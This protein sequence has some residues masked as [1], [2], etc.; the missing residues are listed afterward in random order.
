MS[1]SSITS[2]DELTSI[3]HSCSAVAAFW[4]FVSG[5]AQRILQQYFLKLMT[6]A[7]IL[8]WRWTHPKSECVEPQVTS[9][10]V[11]VDPFVERIKNPWT[12]NIRERFR[13]GLAEQ[14]GFQRPSNRGGDSASSSGLH[15]GTSRGADYGLRS[16]VNEGGTPWRPLSEDHIHEHIMEQER[17]LFVPT[18]EGENQGSVSVSA[19]EHIHEHIVESTVTFHVLQVK[20]KIAV[21]CQSLL[22]ERIHE[23]IVDS[24]FPGSV[25]V[26]SGK[27]V[28]LVVTLRRSCLKRRWHGHAKMSSFRRCAWWD[29]EA[30]SRGAFSEGSGSAWVPN[31]ERGLAVSPSWGSDWLSLQGAACFFRTVMTFLWQW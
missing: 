16:T 15:P 31:A 24:S 26:G 22:Q 10:R 9:R 13:E 29:H 12:H 21:M 19:S 27:R 8:G 5:D 18:D 28:N 20:K 3:R 30:A 17:V 1:A 6:G 4:H 11:C 25:V 23:H 7:Y 2:L 14:C